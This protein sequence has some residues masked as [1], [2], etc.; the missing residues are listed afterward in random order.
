MLTP[1][2]TTPLA[3]K[4]TDGLQTLSHLNEVTITNPKD[5]AQLPHITSIRRLK[6]SGLSPKC[7]D[8]QW[9]RDIRDFQELDIEIDESEEW[10][11]DSKSSTHY[12]SKLFVRDNNTEIVINHQETTKIFVQILE[13]LPG[14]MHNNVSFAQIMDNFK[15]K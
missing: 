12:Q 2:L 11:V 1:R 8:W 10:K 7:A 14:Y 9:M 13:C 3:I 5:V 15:S 4:L 6:M